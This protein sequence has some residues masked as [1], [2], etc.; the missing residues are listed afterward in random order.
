MPIP[1]QKAARLSAI[2]GVPT[3]S[4]LTLKLFFTEAC[5]PLV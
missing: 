1:G 4:L 2:F 5:D 3:H